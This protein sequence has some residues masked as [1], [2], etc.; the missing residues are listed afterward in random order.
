MW[1][2][3]RNI[4][5]LKNNNKEVP[6]QEKKEMRGSRARNRRDDDYYITEDDDAG[7]LGSIWCGTLAIIL[8]WLL[9]TTIVFGLLLWDLNNRVGKLS[10]DIR[11][12][13]DRLEQN[14]SDNGECC[15]NNSDLINSFRPC[16]DEYC[17][18]FPRLLGAVICKGCWDALTNTPTLTSGVGVNGDM[19]YVCVAGNT[20]IEGITD[21]E[22]GD[23]L[24][25]I[26][27]TPT[28]ARWIK[29]DGSPVAGVVTTL[30]DAGPGA[31]LITDG[32][33]DTLAIRKLGCSSGVACVENGDEMQITSTTP[34]VSSGEFMPFITWIPIPLQMTEFFPNVHLVNRLHVPSL[35]YA[36]GFVGDTCSYHRIENE[37][38]VECKLRLLVIGPGFEMAY[39]DPLPCITCTGPVVSAGRFELGGLPAVIDPA[40]QA[41]NDE[42]GHGSVI[43]AEWA[44]ETSSSYFSRICGQM[45]IIDFFRTDNRIQFDISYDPGD[46]CLGITERH[47]LSFSFSYELG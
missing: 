35:T 43:A 20:N 18:N 41:S 47:H 9:V 30:S 22:E 23:S 4:I 24:K 19:Y 40:V 11:T 21:W 31:S 46:G 2:A 37:V 8:I 5:F 12:G 15:Q 13:F 34:F 16:L 45:Q 32:V 17:D 36:I 26:V 6:S 10:D 29:N 3:R 38:F 7:I 14:I 33:G 42:K 28:G 27:N 1:K 25:F 39:V 44:S